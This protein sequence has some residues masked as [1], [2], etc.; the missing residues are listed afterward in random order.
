MADVLEDWYLPDVVSSAVSEG[1]ASPTVAIVV[2]TEQK[3]KVKILGS[4]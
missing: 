4:G 1:P 2:V 3:K